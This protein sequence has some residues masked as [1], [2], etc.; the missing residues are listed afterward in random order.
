MEQ[1]KEVFGFFFGGWGGF[2]DRTVQTMVR[3]F[4]KGGFCMIWEDNSAWVLW[5]SF[6]PLSNETKLS[7]V[8]EWFKSCR[9]SLQGAESISQPWA[10]QHGSLMDSVPQSRTTLNWFKRLFCQK[11]KVPL[12]NL[13]FQRK[14]IILT[15]LLPWCYDENLW[16][17]LTND[18]KFEGQT[19]AK[20]SSFVWK[21]F[22]YYRRAC[23]PDNKIFPFFLIV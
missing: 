10:C 13:F 21:Y 9:V 3:K 23:L 11:V 14:K 2:T 15:F 5:A 1:V 16:Q 18:L 12:D 8:L 4:C 6:I 17:T 20:L 19:I 22:C 7:N